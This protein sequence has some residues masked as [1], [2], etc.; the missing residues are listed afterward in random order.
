MEQQTTNLYTIKINNF[1]GPLDL[2][3][4]LVE[5]NKMDIYD[6]P[7]NEITDQYIEYINA[8]EKINLEITSE[9]LV[10]ASNLLLIK[11]KLL[12]PS[13]KEVEQEE[14]PRQDLILKLIEYKKFKEFSTQLRTNE[15]RYSKIFYKLPEKISMPKQ[16]KIELSYPSQLLYNIYL[17]I[18]TKNFQKQN[19][20]ARSIEK[21]AIYEK[22][23]V[24]S[25]IR[26]ILKE[27][28]KAGVVKFNRIFSIDKKPKIE[29]VTAFLGML[30]LAKVKRVSIDQKELFGDIE[31]QKLSKDKQ[32]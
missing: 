16:S 29:I 3:Y 20:N 21:I 24:R 8:M 6:I 31:I 13:K 27:L 28:F 26:E 17:D 4:H 30:E 22:V 11:S 1:E 32:R 23:T 5:K 9:F 10:M 15:Q 19:I 18:V 7:I 25:K 2:L 12:I 14:D